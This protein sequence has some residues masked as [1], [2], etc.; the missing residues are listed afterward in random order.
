MVRDFFELMDVITGY[1]RAAVVTAAYRIG[2]FA[3]LGSEPRTLDEL[4][5]ALEVA[6]TGSLSAL[7]ESL[8]GM[9]LVAHGPDGYVVASDVVAELAA[10]DGVGPVIEKEATFARFWLDLDQVV[11]DDAPVLAPWSERLDSEP[12]R[13]RAF[14]D[15]LDVLA[16]RTGP[17][18][19][20]MPCLAP[21]RDVADVGGGLGSYTRVLTEAGSRVTL[22]ELPTVAGWA[23][24]E[25]AD[26]GDRWSLVEAD[27]T[28]H[29]SCGLEASSQ[30][31]VLLSHMLHEFDDEVAAKVLAGAAAALRPGGSLVVSEF[32]GD[33]GP[34]DFG[35]LFDVMMRVET[36]SSARPFAAFAELMAAAGF[37]NIERAPFDEPLMVITAT[38]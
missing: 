37:N 27:V 2:L 31:A 4:G 20:R 13:C 23:R 24:E 5:S 35:P 22:V 12:E 25:L 14:L 21:G 8:A 18:F 19:D 32:A 11:R 38:T 26:L 17:A 9:G 36:G 29:A 1:Q 16:R 15:A 34:G 6:G 30:D 3:E 10:G 7:L 33:G 28:E